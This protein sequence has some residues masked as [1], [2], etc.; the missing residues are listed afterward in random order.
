M[1]L[2]NLFN[3][4]DPLRGATGKTEIQFTPQMRRALSVDITNCPHCGNGHASEN[5]YSEVGSTWTI[6]RATGGR[7]IYLE[8]TVRPFLR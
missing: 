8:M 4:H 6:C 5:V 1:K 2:R 7:R 3:R